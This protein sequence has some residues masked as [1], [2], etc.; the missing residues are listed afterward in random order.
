MVLIHETGVRLPVALLVRFIVIC[1]SFLLFFA[2]SISPAGADDFRFEQMSQGR[3]DEALA[4]IVPIRLLPSNPFYFAISIKENLAGMLKP[5]SLRKA[6]W[7][8]ELSG[9]RLKEAYL[10]LV[11]DDFK[12]ASA[13]LNGYAKFSEKTVGEL[14][15]AKSINQDV[16]TEAAIIDQGLESHLVL[17]SA[18]ENKIGVEGLDYSI[19][20]NFSAAYAGF[21]QMVNSIDQI[22]PG[23]RDKF[24]LK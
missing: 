5:S 1:L 24:L 17:F 16:G 3:V 10:L 21:G 12:N 19:D 8:F 20:E 6:D 2:T 23:I 13:A 9:K 4:R 18:I 11:R 7:N 22:R 15:A 14:K